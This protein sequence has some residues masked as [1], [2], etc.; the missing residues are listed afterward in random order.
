MNHTGRQQAAGN[1]VGRCPP[2]HQPKHFSCPLLLGGLTATDKLDTL[3]S[4]FTQSWGGDGV[5]G[6]LGSRG[7]SLASYMYARTPCPFQ[8]CFFYLR[9]DRCYVLL[10][11]KAWC[12]RRNTSV[13]RALPRAMPERGR[14]F[15]YLTSFFPTCF[16]GWEMLLKNKRQLWPPFLCSFLEERL[17]MGI[18]FFEAF[19]S[20]V[21]FT[22]QCISRA[23]M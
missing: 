2:A 12:I 18:L 14:A 3:V 8:S 22:E 7:I 6:C 11:L 4:Q 20:S 15:L 5:G 1:R 21:L 13:Y 23:V 9:V 19:W 10:F 16:I 17:N